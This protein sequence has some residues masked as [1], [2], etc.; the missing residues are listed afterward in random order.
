MQYIYYKITVHGQIVWVPSGTRCLILSCNS[1]D[2]LW[3]PALEPFKK[4]ILPLSFYQEEQET[5]FSKNPS[6]H[7]IF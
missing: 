3:F 5:A 6:K 1:L 4:L 7:N 2:F